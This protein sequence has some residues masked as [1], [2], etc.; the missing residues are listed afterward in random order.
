MMYPYLHVNDAINGWHLNV[1]PCSYVWSGSS[2]R[3][4]AQ[5]CDDRYNTKV[6]KCIFGASLSMPHA[7]HSALLAQ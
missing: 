1:R 4:M 2:F 3:C 6:S 7:D 5:N